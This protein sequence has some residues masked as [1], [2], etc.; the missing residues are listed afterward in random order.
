M[1]P[2]SF[3][4]KPVRLEPMYSLTAS[5]FDDPEL[6]MMI[7]AEIRVLERGLQVG[8]KELYGRAIARAEIPPAWVADS[9]E[10]EE[11]LAIRLWDMKHGFFKLGSLP[12][13]DP[14]IRRQLSGF[15]LWSPQ[16]GNRPK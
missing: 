7:A 3:E 8:S 12:N 10:N 1:S 6:D 9:F 2:D 4:R 13:D 15:T 14:W 16:P 11:A 5:M